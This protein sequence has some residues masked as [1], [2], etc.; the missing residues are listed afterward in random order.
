[1]AESRPVGSSANNVFYNRA[2]RAVLPQLP[3]G[4]LENS[5]MRH[6]G[7]SAIDYSQITCATF[8]CLVCFIGYS[9]RRFTVE[10]VFGPSG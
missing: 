4:L 3:C 5:K 9:R 2:A 7:D 1:M 10:S 6:L 8:R